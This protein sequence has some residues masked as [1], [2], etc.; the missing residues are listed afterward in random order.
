MRPNRLQ[1]QLQSHLPSHGMSAMLGHI[2]WPYDSPASSLYP[3]TSM[4]RSKKTPSVMQAVEDNA[5]SEHPA[6]PG[7]GGVSA[8]PTG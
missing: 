7:V 4:R 1:C 6:K 5:A 8:Q 2:C 3:S